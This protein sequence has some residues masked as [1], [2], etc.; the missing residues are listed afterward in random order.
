MAEQTRTMMTAEEFEAL[1]ESQHPTELIKGELVVRGSPTIKHQNVVFNIAYMIRNK[2]PNGKAYVSPVSVKLNDQ[3]YYQPDVLW[4]SNS[5]TQCTVNNDG[6][7]GAA[8]LVVEVI[9]PGTAKADRGVKFEMYQDSGVR[10][11]WIVEPEEEFVEVWELQSDVYI[12]LGLFTTSDTFTSPTLTAPIPVED[13][14][15]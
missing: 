13:I 7:D 3:N 6:I 12:K 11:Y 5:N 2:I 8:D 15:Q 4:I 10:E 14:F 1:P 9:S